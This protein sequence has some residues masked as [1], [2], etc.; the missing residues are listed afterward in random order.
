MNI[1]WPWKRARQTKTGEHAEGHQALKE[2]CHALEEV[3]ARWPEVLDVAETMRA[4]DH[5][6]H[7]A[8][9]LSM[10][11]GVHRRDADRNRRRDD[12]R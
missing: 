12:P 6:N 4:W 8:E 11:Y 7:F 3:R 2:A 1:T 10:A 9:S 5:G